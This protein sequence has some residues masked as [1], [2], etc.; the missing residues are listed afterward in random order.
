MNGAHGEAIAALQS[1]TEARH[2]ENLRNF[3]RIEKSIL[4][5][6]K[7]IDTLKRWMLSSTCAMALLLLKE[8]IALLNAHI[9]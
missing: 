4:Q 5:L 6:E 9:H 3:A 7:S 8:L 2:D 1:S